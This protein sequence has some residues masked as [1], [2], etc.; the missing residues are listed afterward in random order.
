MTV[1]ETLMSVTERQVS[2][3]E[4]LMSVTETQTS[5]IEAQVSVTDT[6]MNVTVTLMCVT[7]NGRVL[8]AEHHMCSAVL[9]NSQESPRLDTCYIWTRLMMS[10]QTSKRI[11]DTNSEKTMRRQIWNADEIR[12]QAEPCIRL[13]VGVRTLCLVYVAE[14]GTYSFL[15]LIRQEGLE[16][17]KD[18]LHNG[19]HVDMV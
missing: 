13:Q 7:A 16:H 11:N 3:T 15:H 5:V 9:P 12:R 18:T 19:W 17:L 6:A 14:I 2:V 8:P 1:T 4:T 10:Q